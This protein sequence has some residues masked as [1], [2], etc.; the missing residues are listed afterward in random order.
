MNEFKFLE[1]APAAYCQSF[2]DGP[3][4]DKDAVGVFLTSLVDR[5][6]LEILNSRAWKCVS[7]GKRAKEIFH[8]IAS[9]GSP[10]RMTFDSRPTIDEA[11]AP[12]CISGGAC[13]LKALEM[14]HAF[15]KRTLISP[16]QTYSKGICCDACGKVSG[17]RRC[18]GCKVLA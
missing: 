15:A 1:Q 8:S 13:D 4:P 2:I 6:H 18:G 10:C 11:A 16:W 3:T 17:V 5:Y 9:S 7:C 14:V 12:I